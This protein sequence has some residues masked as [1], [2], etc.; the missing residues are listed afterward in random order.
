M[1][2]A[3][4]AAPETAVATTS[5]SASRGSNEI[6]QSSGS[7]EGSST[8]K[9]HRTNSTT[10]GTTIEA[11]DSSDSKLST[12]SSS[13]RT[14]HAQSLLSM[15]SSTVS[16]TSGSNAAKKRKK[17]SVADA[18]V[19]QEENEAT[20]TLGGEFTSLNVPKRRR[21]SGIGALPSVGTSVA[22]D[23]NGST[24]QQRP[25][26]AASKDVGD[27]ANSSGDT[28][29]GQGGDEGGGSGSGSGSERDTEEGGN[30]QRGRSRRHYGGSSKPFTV[31]SYSGSGLASEGGGAP[32]DYPSLSVESLER[33]NQG[34]QE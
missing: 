3:A 15:A 5:R 32:G 14:G 21:V 25:G 30:I 26:R 13:S 29:A 9:T 22:D 28:S 34:G 27:G 23:S 1:A 6:D 33:H 10:A 7:G 19:K 20:D 8:N 31:P 2:A 16:P 18:P 17:A 11:G 12:N 4:E 24:H